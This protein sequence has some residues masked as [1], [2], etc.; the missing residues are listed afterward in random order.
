MCYR[1]TNSRKLE[2]M[3][4]LEKV[5]LLAEKHLDETMKTNQCSHSQ[6]NQKLPFCCQK[7]FFQTPSMRTRHKF[8]PERFL[9]TLS[10][11]IFPVHHTHNCHK[12]CG[13]NSGLEARSVSFTRVQY[14][15]YTYMLYMDIKCTHTFM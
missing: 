5:N 7:I 3:W 8:S 10:G 1:Q 12:T 2:Y 14:N 11:Y 4:A 13:R 6:G 9:C 15:I